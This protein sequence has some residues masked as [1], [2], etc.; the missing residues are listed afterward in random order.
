MAR[1]PLHKRW[2]FVTL[3]GVCGIVSLTGG[4]YYTWLR[5]AP[6]LPSTAEQALETLQSDRFKR[7][8]E[9]RRQAYYDRSA[10]LWKSLDSDAQRDLRAAMQDNTAAREAVRDMMAN[11]MLENARKFA[12]A[13]EEQRQGQLDAVIAMQELAAKRWQQREEKP[14]E[15]GD[16]ER[17]QKRMENGKQRIQQWIETGNPQRQAWMGEFLKALHA[18]R[19]ERG[20]DPDA[21][22]GRPR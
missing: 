13:T 4:G 8:P 20:L 3:L 11:M 7:L 12:T 22:F 10:E 21:G 5:T 1:K 9:S 19:Q 6:P 2:W 15:T 18:R 16:A 17:R 14:V